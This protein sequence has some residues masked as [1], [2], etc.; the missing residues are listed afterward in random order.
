MGA[1][2]EIFGIV[3]LSSVKF[4][5]APFIA[6][7]S[8]FGYLKTIVITF[9]GG[10][11]GILFFY[12]L[13]SVFFK[14]LGDSRKKDG[15]KPKKKIFT[16]TNKFIVRIKSKYGLVGLSIITPAVISI[17]IGTILASK[18]FRKDPKT[19]TYLILSLLVWCFV[20]TSIAFFF[21]QSVSLFS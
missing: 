14:K 19:L 2:W 12:F 13:G 9:S 20:L 4:L 7:A 8:G 10:C 11:I 17:P 6:V 5:P 15:I 18:Y 16:R 1:F 3:L 21:K